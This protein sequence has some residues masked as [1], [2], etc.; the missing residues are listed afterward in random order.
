MELTEELKI[1]LEKNETHVLSVSTLKKLDDIEKLTEHLSVPSRHYRDVQIVGSRSSPASP[2]QKPTASR[3]ALRDSATKPESPHHDR[4]H[5][6]D[7]Q[8]ARSSSTRLR[9]RTRPCAFP[10]PFLATHHDQHISTSSL[11]RNR[12]LT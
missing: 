10:G 6:P 2:S 1:K 7:H 4:R 8:P 3:F 11:Y 12:E 9:Q 5:P